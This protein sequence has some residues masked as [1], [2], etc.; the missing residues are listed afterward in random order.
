MRFLA[1]VMYA[2]DDL[3]QYVVEDSPR[4]LERPC[5]GSLDHEWGRVEIRRDDGRIVGSHEIVERMV[6]SDIPKAHAAF[7]ACV[8][9]LLN[10]CDEALAA[11]FSIRGLPLRG[12]HLF[13][14][15][16]HLVEIVH[17]SGEIFLWKDRD[18][19]DVL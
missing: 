3:L 15:L 18:G 12:E 4:R 8:P 19:L 13:I 16:K 2:A 10:A 7:V 14:V 5:S 6:G 1:A 9:R 17:I 11:T